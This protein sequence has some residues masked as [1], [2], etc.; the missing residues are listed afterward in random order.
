MWAGEFTLRLECYGNSNDAGS[1]PLAGTATRASKG[2]AYAQH[3]AVNYGVTDSLSAFPLHQMIS[4]MTTTINNN[5][6]SMSVRDVLP[7]LLRMCDPEELEMYD[8]TTPATLDYIGHYR[9]GVDVTAYQI[10]Q[11]SQGGAT[12]PIIVG[13]GAPRDATAIDTAGAAAGLGTQK[14]VQS[15]RMSGTR[16]NLLQGRPT[17]CLWI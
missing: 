4:T 13:V 2:T 6:V 14:L 17:S 12:R 10:L 1:A 15:Q 11:S 8:S 16:E 3:F 9:D 7:A 5:S